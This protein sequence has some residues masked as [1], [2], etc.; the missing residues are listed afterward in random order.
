M[1][2]LD[3]HKAMVDMIRNILSVSSLRE[4]LSKVLKAIE[5]DHLPRAI[6]KNNEVS[7]YMIDKD[8]YE[9]L[10]EKSSKFDDLID[11]IENA[12]LFK[13]AEE[14]LANSNP[15]E[16]ISFEEVVEDSGL[17]ME[18]LLAAVDDVEIEYED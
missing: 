3:S 17:T 18:E 10:V 5:M 15:E 9:E 6:T 7:A 2:K 4:N 13:L 8:S 11:R 16:Y 1:G 14:R 12:R